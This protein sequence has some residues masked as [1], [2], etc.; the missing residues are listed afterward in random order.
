VCD[1]CEERA[2]TLAKEGRDLED[3]GYRTDENQP[4]LVK[5]V[6]SVKPVQFLVVR[7]RSTSKVDNNKY[8]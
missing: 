1:Y 5:Q 8:E 7:N 3:A 2:L 6:R 4:M